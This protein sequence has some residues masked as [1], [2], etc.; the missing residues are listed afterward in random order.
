MRLLCKCSYK[1]PLAYFHA[2]LFLGIF[3]YIQFRVLKAEFYGLF[4]KGMKLLAQMP[5]RAYSILYQVSNLLCN[6]CFMM[7]ASVEDKVEARQR[8]DRD[9]GGAF[10]CADV[11]PHSSY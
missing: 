5:E 8:P 3:N 7:G 2:L 11:D 10:Q 1:K 6:I 9:Q 4:R